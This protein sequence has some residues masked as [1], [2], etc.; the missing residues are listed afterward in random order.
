MKYVRNSRPLGKRRRRK[1]D[2][3]QSKGLGQQNTT[4]NF[5]SLLFRIQ[6]VLDTAKSS[7]I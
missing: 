1:T 6:S 4:R 2:N 3:I 7:E 5:F